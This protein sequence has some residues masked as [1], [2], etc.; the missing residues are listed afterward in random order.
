MAGASI[1]IMN[2]DK[3]I[4]EEKIKITSHINIGSGS[5]I[6]IKDLAEAIKKV[7]EYKGQINYDTNKPDGS[8]RKILDSSL[9]NNLGWKPKKNL[10]DGLAITY[11]NFI[12]SK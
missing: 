2:L 8:V 11:K 7:T 6:S 5:E 10:N 1:Y 12:K 9:I 4:Y 3:K